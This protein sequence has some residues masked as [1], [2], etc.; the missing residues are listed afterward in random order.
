MKKI[1]FRIVSPLENMMCN[2]REE[3]QYMVWEEIENTK[4]ALQ[5]FKKR[6]L[7]N[8]AIEKML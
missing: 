2:I 3:G 5:R 6:E 7:F 8:S 4:D 1:K